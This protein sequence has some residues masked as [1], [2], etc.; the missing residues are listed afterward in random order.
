VRGDTIG[1]TDPVPQRLTAFLPD[2]AA[3]PFPLQVF[4]SQMRTAIVAPF[5]VDAVGGSGEGSVAE[6]MD[7][8]GVGG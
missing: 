4:D 7:L 6:A 2:P 3:V 1:V 8:G 5:Q